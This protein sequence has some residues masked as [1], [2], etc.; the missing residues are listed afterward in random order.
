MFRQCTAITPEAL[1]ACSHMDLPSKK[2]NSAMA[3]KIR[4]STA[5]SA[6]LRLFTTTESAAQIRY[7]SI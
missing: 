7:P 1:L 6:P 5:S 2:S 3:L 4:C